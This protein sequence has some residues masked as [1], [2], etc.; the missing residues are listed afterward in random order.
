M[1]SVLRIYHD[2][3]PVICNGCNG[4][5]CRACRGMGEVAGPSFTRWECGACGADGEGDPQECPNCA[6]DERREYGDP[7]PATAA[8]DFDP[9]EPD[10]V[11]W[12]DNP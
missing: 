3:E 5:G 12:D 11:E 7:E 2:S 6:C 10:P 8:D 4:T 1:A 9:P